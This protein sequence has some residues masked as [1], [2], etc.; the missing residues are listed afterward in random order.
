MNTYADKK[1][2][3][4]NRAGVN[5]YS[6]KQANSESAYP[7]I[8]NRPEAATQKK[9]QEMAHN[10]PQVRQMKASQEIANNSPQSK[11]AAQ[12]QAMVN[13]Y[14]ARQYKP[15][16]KNGN[17]TGLPDDLKAGVENISGYS[18]D[19][20]KVHYNSDK[21]AEL[22]A[23]AYAQGT[24]IHISPGQEKHLP[25]EAWHV[26]QQKQGRVK[27]TIQ[28][29]GNVNVNNDAGLET[30]ADEMGE[31][32]ATQDSIH[33]K[34]CGC[35]ACSSNTI[36]STLQAKPVVQ[37]YCGLPGCTDPKCDD[38]ENHKISHFRRL[39]SVDIYNA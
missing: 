17:N 2:E 22:Q 8:D 19:D 37:R 14:S 30:E 20:V 4:I 11:Q 38:T 1:T 24:D 21:P 23:H 18:M 16:Q 32:V 29:K 13:G 26:V 10:S 9:V 15:I 6:H 33:H 7:F 28:M 3:N 5:K 25:H 36:N 31:K 27:P 39:R 34:A 35:A 12:L